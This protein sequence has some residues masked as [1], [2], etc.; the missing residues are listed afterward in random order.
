MDP[1]AHYEAEVMALGSAATRMLDAGVSQEHVARWI[2]AQRNALKQR[3][4]ALTPPDD[5]VR[6]EAWTLG[7]YGNALGPSVE[8]LRDAGK[9]WREI[10]DGA[11]RPGRYRGRP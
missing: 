9:S 4:R 8:W 2:V 5:R 11:T 7:R 3:F 1:R 6:L 10:I